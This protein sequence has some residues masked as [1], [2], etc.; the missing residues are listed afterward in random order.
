MEENYYVVGMG[1]K[2]PIARWDT[3]EK[4]NA[5]LKSLVDECQIPKQYLSVHTG[6]ESV[7]AFLKLKKL[8]LAPIEIYLGWYRRMIHTNRW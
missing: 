8:K 2:W 1:L 5:H 6:D 4:A 7:M 3:L